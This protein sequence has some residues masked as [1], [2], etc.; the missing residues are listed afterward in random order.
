MILIP[1]GATNAPPSPPL[2]DAYNIEHYSDFVLFVDNQL[3]VF[4][5]TQLKNQ[6]FLPTFWADNEV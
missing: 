3:K 2:Q 1:K 4:L 5:K 6:A